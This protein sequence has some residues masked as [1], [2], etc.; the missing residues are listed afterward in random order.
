MKKRTS[1][2]N[3]AAHIAQFVPVMIWLFKNRY[4]KGR[5]FVPRLT[6]S[7]EYKGQNEYGIYLRYDYIDDETIGDRNLTEDEIY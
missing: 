6:S 2:S 4:L 7:Q 5:I 3:L 1:I